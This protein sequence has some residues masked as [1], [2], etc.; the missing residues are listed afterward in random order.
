MWVEVLVK[1]MEVVEVEVVKEVVK[2]VVEKV[3]RLQNSQGL[4]ICFSL[5]F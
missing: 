5:D 3:D 1:K 2:E 4:E